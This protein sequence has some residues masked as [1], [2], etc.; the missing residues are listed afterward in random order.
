M[1]RRPAVPRYWRNIALPL[2]Q[3]TV[4]RA[5]AESP[6]RV[7]HWLLVLEAKNIPFRYFD[8][9]RAISLY[10]PPT[11]VLAAIREISAFET[12]KPA[13]P[14]P[15]PPDRPG[16]YWFIVLLVPLI[17]W[18]R[19]RWN[20]S[21]SFSSLPSSGPDWLAPAGLDAYRVSQTGEWWRAITALTLH[22]DGAHLTANLVMGC[23]FGIPL[24]R[25]TGIGVGFLLTVLAGGW[26]NIA[27]ACLRPA[28]FMSQGFSTAVFAAAGL[29]AAFSAVFAARH[30]HSQAPDSRE[31]LKQAFFKALPPIGAG[32]AFLALLG[33]S[34]APKVDY[35]AHAMGLVA[36]IL[37]GLPAALAAPG[38][39]TLRGG[40]NVVLQAVC[41]LAAYA[42]IIRA[43]AMALP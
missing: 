30:A 25:Y 36:G 24:C 27:T 19:I 39:L 6:S 1:S 35:L 29:L 38:L 17:P 34:D 40:K 42:V 8:K 22:A 10:V 12:E 7:R 28:N 33:G 13:P 4:P 16:C 26:G 9:G 5:L 23:V 18:H 2:R 41:G 32:F 11:A 43:W 14:L 21:V 31:A 37:T 3:R 15:V 20:Q